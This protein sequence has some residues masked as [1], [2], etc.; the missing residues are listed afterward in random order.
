MFFALEMFSI[1]GAGVGVGSEWGGSERYY[2]HY[3]FDSRM[4]VA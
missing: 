3:K 4:V 1:R 2:H